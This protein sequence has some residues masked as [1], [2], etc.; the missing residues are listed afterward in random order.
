MTG[1]VRRLMWSD[2]GSNEIH[3]TLLQYSV[4]ILVLL[5]VFSYIVDKV[6]LEIFKYFFE[7]KLVIVIN[8][9]FK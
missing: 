3:V 1:C 6:I 2:N 4:T 5:T 9:I 8:Y 7:T